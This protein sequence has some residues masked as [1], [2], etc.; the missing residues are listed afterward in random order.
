MSRLLYIQASPRGERSTSIAVAEAFVNAYR[1][2]HPSDAI[3]RLNLF[4]NELP[5]FDGFTLNAK[6]AV[7]NGLNHTPEEKAAWSKVTAIADEFKSYDKYVLA[8]PM[9]NFS[10]PY[11]LKHYLDVLIQPDLTFSFSPESGYKGLVTGKPAFVALA[12]GGEYP[13]GSPSEAWDFQS[14][15]LLAALGFIGFTDIRVVMAE[16]TLGD[17]ALAAKRRDEAISIAAAMAA[18]F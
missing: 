17:P 13:P 2:S 16:P 9:W 15:Y 7:L 10:I 18:A 12:R 14:K 1:K 5:P 4:Q 3:T 8:S 11:K 6:Y